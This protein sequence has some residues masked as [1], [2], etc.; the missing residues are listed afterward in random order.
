MTQVK[1]GKIVAT[2]ND[3]TEN[4]ENVNPTPR[5]EISTSLR[6]KKPKHADRAANKGDGSLL[7]VRQ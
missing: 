7:L 5:R 4:I 3:R 1:S 2:L 6:V